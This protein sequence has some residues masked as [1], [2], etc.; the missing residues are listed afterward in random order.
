MEILRD[1][2]LVAGYG[3]TQEE[4]EANHD[5][6]LKKLLDRARKAN[7]KLNS[8]KMNLKKQQVKFMGHVI[9]QDGLKPDPD[10]VKAVKN[11]PKP[12]CK[13]EALS[14]L[15]FINYLAKF[16]PKLSE[17]AQPLRDLTR[18]NAQFIWSRQHD[19]AFEDMKKLVIQHPVLK[20][21]DIGEEVTLQCDA[22]ERGLG[23]TLM[24]KGQPVAFA[25]RTLSTTE[26]RYAQIE[27]ECL[28]IV[29]GCEKFSQYISRRD[30]VTVES[31]HKPL[32]SIFKKSLLHAPMRLQRMMLRLQRYNLDVVYKPGS[33]MFVADHLSRA[34]LSETEP[35]DEDVHVFALE[36]ETMDPLSTVKISSESLPRLQ[37]TTEEDPVMQTLKNTILVGWPDRKEKVPLNIQEYW[38]FREE[39]TLHN[40]ILFKNQRV[41]IPRAMRPELTNRAH[42]S[43]QG[44]DACIRRAKDVVFWPSMSKDIQEAVEKCEVCAEFQNNN[45]KQPMQ[46]HEIPGR[47]WSRV[48]SDLFTLNSRDYIVLVDSYSDF[49]E[50]GELRSTNS[51]DIIRFLKQQFSRHGIPNVLV[52]DNGP[53]FSSSEF[54][55]FSSTWEFKH[56]TSSPTHA[57]SNGKAESAV[58]VVKKMFKKAHRDSK[59]PWLALLDQRNTPTQ[60]VGSSPAQRLMSRRTRTLL[61]IAANLL[62]PKVEEGVTKMLKLKRQKAKSYH[63]RSSIVLPELEIGQ[64]VRVA[65]QRNKTWEAGTCVEKL[66]DRSYMVEVNGAIIRRNREALKPKRDIGPHN[67]G[68]TKTP[69]GTDKPKQKEPVSELNVQNSNKATAQMLKSGTQQSTPAVPLRA[70]RTRTVKAPIRYGYDE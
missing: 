17:V 19:K 55:T 16:L 44:I 48:S 46:S 56:V 21:Y 68:E 69:P 7:L 43:H 15:G 24:Q 13:Q 23:A 3:D 11:M 37:K 39:L 65:G 38:N 64:E 70:T 35:D 32:Q 66:S 8:K 67:Q 36:L 22:S 33:Q 34:F 50:V 28:A 12:K 30:K 26:Q 57:K 9:T 18:A 51:S 62:Y 40:G 2:I 1:D 47:P 61:P 20:Y 27:K 45:S 59:D 54:T 41:I 58:K 14:L 29:F 10:K 31:D 42:S 49:I 53:Q 25:S 63:D 4:A 6:N 60:G 52:T 5:E